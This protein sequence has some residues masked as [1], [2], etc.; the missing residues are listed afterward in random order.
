MSDKRVEVIEL[1]GKITIRAPYDEDF[2]EDLKT[3]FGGR[4]DPEEKLWWV[5]SQDYSIQD[6]LK[7]VKLH[8][9]NYQH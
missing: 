6:V 4:W 3:D 2:K 7:L 1:E 5:N 8:F 9:P